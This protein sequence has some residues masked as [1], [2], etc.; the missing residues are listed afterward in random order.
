M[1]IMNKRKEELKE[2]IKAL[3]KELYLASVEEAEEFRSLTSKFKYHWILDS[4]IRPYGTGG[5][6]VFW[7]VFYDYIV[8]NSVS[9]H[10]I[11]EEDG[12]ERRNKLL[13]L[14]SEGKIGILPIEIG[15]F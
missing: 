1:N 6:K 8:D 14:Q 5:I 15:E 13:N 2:K 12:A 9:L 11:A 4:G 3:Q 7:V 10:D